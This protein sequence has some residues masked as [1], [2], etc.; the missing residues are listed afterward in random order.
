MVAANTAVYRGAGVMTLSCTPNAYNNSIVRNRCTST[1]STATGGG[2][3]AYSGSAIQGSNNIVYFNVA[4]TNPQYS[5]VVNFTYSCCAQALTG[6]GNFTSDPQFVNNPPAG[7]FYLSQIAAGQGSN[8][9]CVNAGH[10]STPMVTGSTRTDMVQDAVVVD[11]GFHW[12]S[13]MSDGGCF[14]ASIGED[15]EELFVE[16]TPTSLELRA[17]NYPNPFNPNTTIKLYVPESGYLLL[18]VTDISGR[19]VQALHQGRISGGSQEFQF[20]GAEMPSGIYFYRAE[21]NGH[22]TTGKALLI[23]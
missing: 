20:S 4:T 15:L 7:Y 8:S 2:I 10:P 5:G 1:S 9:P 19:T 11:M 21:M 16:S 23:K 6:T 14:A 13:V 3:C 18:T 22:T 12:I 17:S